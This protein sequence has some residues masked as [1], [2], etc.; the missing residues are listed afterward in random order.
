[1]SSNLTVSTSRPP[2]PPGGAGTLIANWGLI[3]AMDFDQD[4][5]PEGAHAV[6]RAFALACRVERDR[7]AL[8]DRRIADAFAARLIAAAKG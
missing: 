4:D 1:M 2:P 7:R 3:P 8:A 6:F 5:S